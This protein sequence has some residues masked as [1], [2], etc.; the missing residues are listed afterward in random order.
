MAK[1]PGNKRHLA[2]GALEQAEETMPAKEIVFDIYS[3]VLEKKSV[4]VESVRGLDAAKERMEQIA[5]Q[6]LG[7]YF[8]FDP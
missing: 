8:I 1:M 3:G 6:K 4:W 7:N 5:D 2:M